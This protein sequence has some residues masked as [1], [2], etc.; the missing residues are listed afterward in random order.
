MRCSILKSFEQY[1]TEPLQL[2]SELEVAFLLR[3]IKVHQCVL[4][5]GHSH[6]FG[7]EIELSDMKFRA[8]YVLFVV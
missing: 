5:R 4:L 6:S 2:H 7:E 8:G 3:G 1:L